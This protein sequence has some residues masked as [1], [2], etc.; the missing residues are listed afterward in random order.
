MLI[1]VPP[2]IPIFNIIKVIDIR[3][4][5]QSYICKAG[6]VTVCAGGCCTN[7]GFGHAFRLRGDNMRRAGR[8][9]LRWISVATRSS[10]F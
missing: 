4:T 3:Q 10:S 9:G 7:S 1:A 8:A 2:V 5:S 6:E